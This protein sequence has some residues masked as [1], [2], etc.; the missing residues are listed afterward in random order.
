MDTSTRLVE[1][2]GARRGWAA[3]DSSTGWVP[4]TTSL[5]DPARGATGSPKTRTSACASQVSNQTVYG[6]NFSV[7]LNKGEVLQATLDVKYGY[8]E[9]IAPNDISLVQFPHHDGQIQ[10]TDPNGSH[11]AFA[12]TYGTATSAIGGTSSSDANVVFTADA[13]GYYY[14][15]LH[16]DQ[17]EP[18]YTLG[19]GQDSLPSEGIAYTAAL[20]PIGMSTTTDAQLEVVA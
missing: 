1:T 13:T 20:R 7:Y 2:A 17:G 4:S 16:T 9:T 19:L 18:A 15:S 3:T 14:F 5:T 6:D 11:V 12:S 8:G 10:V